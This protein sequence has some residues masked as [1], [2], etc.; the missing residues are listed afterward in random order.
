MLARSTH[1]VRLLQLSLYHQRLMG[2]AALAEDLGPSPSIH[3]RRFKTAYN[4]N[5]RNS[6]SSSG[7]HRHWAYVMQYR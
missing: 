6:T 3:V 4:S 5:S 7:L 1:P 2:I